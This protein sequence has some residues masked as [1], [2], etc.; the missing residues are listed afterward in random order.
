MVKTFF[1]RKTT[2][3]VRCAE[4]SRVS[5]YAPTPLPVHT[6][7]P[8]YT[9]SNTP[10]FWHHA[11]RTRSIA[12]ASRWRRLR[13]QRRHL[14]DGNDGSDG[15]DGGGFSS[16]GFGG[17]GDGDGGD[18]SHCG[19]IGTPHFL[20]RRAATRR[21]LAPIAA[22]PHGFSCWQRGDPNGTTAAHADPLFCGGPT[23]TY[24]PPTGAPAS[25]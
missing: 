15:S 21:P 18:G 24:P 2:T 10:T 19:D 14:S 5:T 4:E 23:V 7:N 22:G 12:P 20:R 11:A 17:R 6:Y 8:R 3:R 16:G 13:R 1:S 9:S 25:E